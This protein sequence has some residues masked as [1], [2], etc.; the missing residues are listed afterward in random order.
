VRRVKYTDLNGDIKEI[1]VFSDPTQTLLT[2]V[3]DTIRPEAPLAEVINQ[4][5]TGDIISQVNIKWNKTC[6]N[7]TYVLS[8]LNT[9]NA[10]Q[11]IVEITTNDPSQLIYSWNCNLNK[12]D[13][14]GKQVF[15]KIKVDVTNTSGL[16]N[17]SDHTVS[18]NLPPSI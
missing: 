12:F 3:V 5:E 16:I 13:D 2:N 10:W 11:K 8:F 18:F 7:G 6:Y 15:Y 14:S 17:R 1:K 9:S 4:V